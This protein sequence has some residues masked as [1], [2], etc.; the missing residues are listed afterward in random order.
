MIAV[1]DLFS[2]VMDGSIRVGADGDERISSL[3][4][5]SNGLSGLQR[6]LRKHGLNPAKIFLVRDGSGPRYIADKSE[7]ELPVFCCFEVNDDFN[8]QGVSEVILEI[9]NK[10][11]RLH[12]VNSR[13]PQAGKEAL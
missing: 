13:K 5:E 10:Y 6:Q 12:A 8:P 3:G 11:A 1:L 7:L 9:T 2:F 4:I